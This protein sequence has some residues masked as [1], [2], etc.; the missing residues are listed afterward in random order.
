MTVEMAMTDQRRQRLDEIVVEINR[1]MPRLAVVA[2]PT[3]ASSVP[4]V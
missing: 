4:R 1:L 2:G 3:F